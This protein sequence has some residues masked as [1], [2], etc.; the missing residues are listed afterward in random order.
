MASTAFSSHDGRLVGRTGL[1]VGQNYKLSVAAGSFSALTYGGTAG[2]V[3]YLAYTWLRQGKG[4][5]A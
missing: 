1:S 4:G 2:L 3:G 5:G